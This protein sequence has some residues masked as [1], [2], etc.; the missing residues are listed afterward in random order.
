MY[1]SKK[2]CILINSAKF[3]VIFRLT[4]ALIWSN[5]FNY[6]NCELNG[7]VS[8]NKNIS[9]RII[10][11]YFILHTTNT[12]RTN[13]F[14][15]FI[16]PHSIFSI[17]K[18]ESCYNIAAQTCTVHTAHTYVPHTAHICNRFTYIFLFFAILYN[19]IWLKLNWL[20]VCWRCFVVQWA[21]ATLIW[22]QFLIIWLCACGIIFENVTVQW[23]QTTK[24][25]LTGWRRRLLRSMCNI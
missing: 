13:N 12:R 23:L 10:F 21:R 25:R 20:L 5:C 7:S 4:K 22:L 11:V 8:S 14:I 6:G 24:Q 9:D 18:S 17:L 3:Y 15:S 1:N 2:N 16:F 19:L